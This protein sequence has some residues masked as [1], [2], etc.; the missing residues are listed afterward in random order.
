VK[1]LLALLAVL[2][3]S[4]S[5]LYFAQHRPRHDAV[6]SN[7]LVNVAADWQRDVTRV[8][9]HFTRISDAEEIQLGAQLAANY[10][11]V[12]PPTTLAQHAL[13]Q[14]ANQVGTRV[15]ARA[16]RK[17]SWHFHLLCDPNFIN[18]FALPGGQIFIG[19]GL[20]DQLKSED[21]L[22]FV[23]GHEIEHVDHFHAVERVQIEARLHHL[24]L[25]AISE[26]A[27][28]PISLWQIGYSKDEELEADRE[29]LRL[30]AAAGY[31]AQG[32]INLLERWVQLHREVVI[33]A[34]TP[35]D[36]LSQLAIEGLTG[37][38]RS[39]PL[40]SERLAQA[41]E[42]IAEDRLPTNAP[43]TPFRAAYDITRGK[44]ALKFP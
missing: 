30:A 28:L 9:M 39:H 8:P 4:A 19:T 40:P 38:F 18:A 22:A 17:L 20:I 33:H 3:V 7:A 35:P 27:S 2:A 26:L 12:D 31:S 32:A 41:T 1:R 23:L 25:D 36:E 42:I 29:G 15:A 16:K 34:E 13:E 24:D 14:Y 37:Y 43:L 10:A 21:E 11:S 5:A 6:S 44:P